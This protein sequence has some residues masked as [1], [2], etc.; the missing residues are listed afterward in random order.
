MNRRMIFGIF[1][2][3]IAILIGFG[4]GLYFLLN[5]DKDNND[6]K[7]RKDTLEISGKERDK[8]IETQNEELRKAQVDSHEI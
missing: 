4:L 7:D 1:G 8:D 3:V 5:D 2:I 6:Y